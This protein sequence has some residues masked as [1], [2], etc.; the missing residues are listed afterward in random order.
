MMN[1]IKYYL[2][3]LGL[4]LFISGCGTL[5]PEPGQAV[6]ATP[7]DA[8]ASLV[9]AVKRNDTS[10]LM[11]IFG[12]QGKNIVFSGDEKYDNDSRLWFSKKAEEKVEVV[13]GEA[14]GIE[15]GNDKWPFPVPIVE[16]DG[17]WFFNTAAGLDEVLIRR[18]GRNELNA[19][20]VC[21]AIVEAQEEFARIKAADGGKEYAL[22]FISEKGKNNGLYWDDPGAKQKSPLGARIA[23]AS[24]ETPQGLGRPYHGYYYMILVSQGP[25]APGGVKSYLSKGKMCKGFAIAAYPAE[26]GV[27]GIKTFMVARNGVVFEKDLGVDTAK[28]LPSMTRFNPDDSWTPVRD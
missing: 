1:R 11:E 10:R 21:R 4:S 18:I 14:V 27:S 2:M 22:R 17:K 15:I 5:K 24:H 23:L 16:Y 7:E 19:I 20:N 3:V 26:Y 8:S 12:P 13:K 9:D 6:F 25:D 28:I